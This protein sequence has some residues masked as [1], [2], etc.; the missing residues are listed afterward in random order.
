MPNGI[1]S[2]GI[3]S[4]FTVAPEVVNL[5]ILA[6]SLST[7]E[8]ETNRFSPDTAI[9]IGPPDVVINAGF[10]VAPEVV[11]LPIV[12]ARRLA[13]N[14]LPPEAAMPYGRLSPEMSA[15]FTVSPEVVY[16]P[17]VSASKFV[18]K[19]C[20]AGLVS[21]IAQSAAAAI[22]AERINR[23]GSEDLVIALSGSLSQDALRCR[24]RNRGSFYAIHESL[25]SFILRS[26]QSVGVLLYEPCNTVVTATETPDLSKSTHRPD[27]QEAQRDKSEQW[28]GPRLK[29]FKSF[30]GF[31]NRGCSG[32]GAT[33]DF[34]SDESCTR[35]DEVGKLIVR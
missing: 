16:S 21:R 28:L 10:T 6:L 11:Y 26:P 20:A 27:G 14:K 34:C 25:S 8:I 31:Q 19:I 29:R 7:L 30:L 22:K 3:R 1:V 15:G 35:W 17:I 13:T 33:D 2:P 23:M 4:S 32:K 18:T 5:A 12:P 9:I 24:M